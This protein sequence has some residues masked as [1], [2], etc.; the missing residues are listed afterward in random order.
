MEMGPYMNTVI[1]IDINTH[2]LPKTPFHSFRYQILNNGTKVNPISDIMS[3]SSIFILISE[4]QSSI[5]LSQISD[6]VST[7]APTTFYN[8]SVPNS[9]ENNILVP[10]APPS[11][12]A[13]CT[14][15]S[16]CRCLDETRISTHKRPR[17]TSTCTGC[18]WQMVCCGVLLLWHFDPAMFYDCN[19]STLECFTTVSS[20]PCNVLLLWHFNPEM[21]HYCNTLIL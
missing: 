1:D 19:T 12:V 21:C 15:D 3:D 2:V 6:W 4:V 11:P 8:C 9:K 14:Q 7:Y 16:K 10:A 13:N 5:I 17:N 20:R 18:H